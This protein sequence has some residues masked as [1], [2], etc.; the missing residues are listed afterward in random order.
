MTIVLKIKI[1]TR[2]L[3]TIYVLAGLDRLG[4][5]HDKYM[6]LTRQFKLNVTSQST[7]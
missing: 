1:N 5:G 3:K 2:Y 6:Q 7:R 4:L